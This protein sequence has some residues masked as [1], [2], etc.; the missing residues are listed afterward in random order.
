[1][2][3]QL[4]VLSL[5]C[6]GVSLPLCWVDLG[7]KPGRWSGSFQPTGTQMPIANGSQ[8]LPFARHV[9]VGRPGVYWA[10]LVR[11]FGNNR[12]QVYYSPTQRRLQSRY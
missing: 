10:G 2:Q 8:T 1:M 4:L 11:F 7:K 9:F 3:I 6:R 5:F 12:V